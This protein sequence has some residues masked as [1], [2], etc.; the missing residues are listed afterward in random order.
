MVLKTNLLKLIYLSLLILLAGCSGVQTFQSSLRAGDTA[1]VAAGWKHDFSRD[2]LLV[3]ITPSVG[4]PVFYLPGNPAVRGVI[5][6]Y[7][8]PLSSMVISQ[9]TNQD[10]TPFAQTYAMGTN[11]FTSGD[12]DWWQTVVFIDL[13]DTLPTGL[14]T[15][16][17]T[18]K[19]G[20]SVT[21]SINII[22]GV[23]QAEGFDA[24]Q[25][26]PLT[27]NQF[28]SL[29][30][31][32]HFVVSFSAGVIPHAIQID[33]SHDPDAANGG[34]GKAYVSNPRGD[35]KSVMW[36]DNGSNLQVLLAPA[37]A[38]SLSSMTEFKF[39]VSGGITNLLASN[40]TAVDINGVPMNG[41][42]AEIVAGK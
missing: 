21:S 9:A 24:E 26:G 42:T 11:F 16:N 41:I 14:A 28:A 25:N 29:E 31:V 2:S 18:N 19:V 22:E 30:R 4:V 5:N 1:A 27:I 23:G 7:P 13:P 6:L 15:I 3:S 20:A 40:I 34:V 35:L 12:K 39:Y 17:I 32:E 37:Q 38:Q 36:N 8:D 33:F 10:I